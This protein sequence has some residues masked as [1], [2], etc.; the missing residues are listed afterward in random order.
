MYF[1]RVP[2][3]LI[4]DNFREF[5]GFHPNTY[6]TSEDFQAVSVPHPQRDFWSVSSIRM[7]KSSTMMACVKVV[8]NNAV[9]AFPI[10]VVLLDLVQSV[11]GYL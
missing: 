5:L 2:N 8:K 10:L 6:P 3:A 1:D 7:I 4:G 11:R 9:R